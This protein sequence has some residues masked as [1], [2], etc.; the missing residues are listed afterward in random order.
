MIRVS[1]LEVVLELR[2]RLFGLLL[3]NVQPAETV[4][5]IRSI[6]RVRSLQCHFQFPDGLLAVLSLLE[7]DPPA[8]VRESG[9]FLILGCKI[10]LIKLRIGSQGHGIRFLRLSCQRGIAVFGASPHSFD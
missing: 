10:I 4:M 6:F 9:I 8:I 1:S 2:N 5:H 3:L 7:Q